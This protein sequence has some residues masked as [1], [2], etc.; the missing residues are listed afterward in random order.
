[1]TDHELL[2]AEMQ[3]AD[4][5]RALGLADELLRL[6]RF[7]EAWEHRKPRVRLRE[8]LATPRAVELDPPPPEGSVPAPVRLFA[9]PTARDI[10]EYDTDDEG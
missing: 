7:R 9:A 4:D 3:T 2:A 10:A 5:A 6:R 1:M 8:I